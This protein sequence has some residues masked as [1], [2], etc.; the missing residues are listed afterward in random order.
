MYTILKSTT[1]E[2]NIEPR[3]NRRPQTAHLV[4]G[5]AEMGTR[6]MAHGE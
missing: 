2:S 4:E 1:L 5:T 6:R 3:R